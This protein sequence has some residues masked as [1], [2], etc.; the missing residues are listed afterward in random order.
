MINLTDTILFY[1]VLERDNG[2]PYRPY[3]GFSRDIPQASLSNAGH[4]M[5][6]SAITYNRSRM[7]HESL[8]QQRQSLPWHSAPNYKESQPQILASRG[9]QDYRSQSY[10]QNNAP[11]HERNRDRNRLQSQSHPQ[12]SYYSSEHESSWGQHTPTPLYM[13]PDR[14]VQLAPGQRQYGYIVTIS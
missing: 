2:K 5:L 1:Y 14:G 6:N 7:S 8:H 9:P 13:M 11:Y 3:I 12:R 10:H 4:R